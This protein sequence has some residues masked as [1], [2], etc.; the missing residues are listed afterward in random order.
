MPVWSIYLLNPFSTQIQNVL[1]G[2]KGQ[3]VLV[4]AHRL[5]T[6][7]R[8]DHI[9]YMENGKIEEQGTHEQLMAQKGLYFHLR[10]KLFTVDSEKDWADSLPLSVN[11]QISNLYGSTEMNLK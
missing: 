9:I 11:L 6:I 10:E 3:T 1:S 5:K 7:E 2:S 8:A 4:I